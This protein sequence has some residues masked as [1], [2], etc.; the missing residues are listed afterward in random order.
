MSELTDYYIKMQRESSP[1]LDISHRCILRCPQCLRQKV[2]GQSRITR[3]FE[4]EPHNFQKILD[5]YDNCITFCGQISDPIY[6]PKF[7]QFLK[8]CDGSGKGIRVATNG[9]LGPRMDMSF[10]EEAYKYCKG[11]ISWYFGVDGLD[12]KSEIYRIGSNFEQVWEAMRLGVKMGHAIVWQYIIFGYNEHEVEQAKEIAKK[13]GF[14]LL[15]IKTNR[16]FDPRSRNLRGNIKKAYENFPVPSD[17]NRV[18]KNKNE[19]Y[20]NVTPELA[21][22]RKVREGLIK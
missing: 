13:E 15:L 7:L 11:E 20:F 4:L 16:G 17:K 22:W 12:K 9:T 6:H 3:S 18:K 1:N 2:E 8:M 21:H 10:F 5:Y 19:E 14:T